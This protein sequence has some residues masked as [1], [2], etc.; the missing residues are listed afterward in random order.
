MNLIQGED[1]FQRWVMA[2]LGV[3]GLEHECHAQD[4]SSF[5][6]DVPDLN[7]TFEG[8]EYW[9][10]LKY[11]E[12]KML[13]SGYDEFS[14]KTMQRGQLDWLERRGNAG[15]YCVGILGYAVMKGNHSTTPYLIFMNPSYYLAT[16]WQKKGFSAGAA[17]MGG[18]S[19]HAHSVK[20]GLD[21]LN[22]L[23]TCLPDRLRKRR[24]L[25]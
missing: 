15:A 8:R 22:F 20:T 5:Q 1:Q 14:W 12:F 11:G 18:Q 13:H 2:R 19:V 3:L 24:Q 17:L 25:G 23:D 6:Y 7:F 9:L 4:F 21:L 10:E 16:V